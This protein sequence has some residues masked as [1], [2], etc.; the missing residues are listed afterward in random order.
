MA[1]DV[2][3]LFPSGLLR[4]GVYV[5]E[6]ETMWPP[7]FERPEAARAAWEQVGDVDAPAA[8]HGED[9]TEPVEVKVFADYGDGMW[10]V[11]VATPSTITLGA[12]WTG[13]IG[14]YSD[15]EWEDEPRS[16]HRERPDWAVAALER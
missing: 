16:V 14:A 5:P 6:E 8:G 7:L 10:W 1:C 12:T 9:G 4:F 13:V 3:V 2:A 11:A 15:I